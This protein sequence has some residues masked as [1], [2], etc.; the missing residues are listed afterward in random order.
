MSMCREQIDYS[1]A[2]QPS[3]YYYTPEDVKPL[4]NRSLSAPAASSPT[5]GSEPDAPSMQVAPQ[6][7]PVQQ[8]LQNCMQA[9]REQSPRY[10]RRARAAVTVPLLSGA[11][12]LAAGEHGTGGDDDGGAHDGP[13]DVDVEI[14]DAVHSVGRSCALFLQETLAAN[15]DT[16]NSLLG[17]MHC[18]CM[19]QL[20]WHVVCD[21]CARCLHG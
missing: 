11:A 2:A 10:S 4:L 7:A 6:S 3:L 1:E 20:D 17:W 5:P 8:Q 14:D 15:S 13:G 19:H 21:C 9:H 18:Q 16:A 12:A